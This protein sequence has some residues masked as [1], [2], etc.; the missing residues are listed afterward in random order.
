MRGGNIMPKIALLNIKGEKLK[1]IKLDDN[2]W[3]IEPNDSVIYDAVILAQASLRQG[4][5]DVKTRAMVRGGGKK[6]WKQ[7]GTGNARQGSIRS[8]QWRGGGIVFGPTSEANYKKKMNKKERKLAVKS[9]LSYKVL[10][11]HLMALDSLTLENSKTKGFVSML[12]DLKLN[13]STLFVT[14]DLSDELILASRNIKGIKIILPTEVNTLD[15]VNYNNLVITQD[16]IKNIEE[17]LK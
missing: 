3:S 17:V 5:H 2:I 16:A 14:V 6:P 1:D 15:V 4:T 13:K 7:K 9:A 10:N 11:S 12:K 8:P